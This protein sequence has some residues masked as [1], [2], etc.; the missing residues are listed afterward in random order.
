MLQYGEIIEKLS[1]DEKLSI[2]TDGRFLASLHAENEDIPALDIRKL[3]SFN[4]AGEYSYPAFGALANTWDCT[5]IEL[6]AKGLSER[7]GE[8]GVNATLLPKANVRSNVYGNGASED[9]YLLGTLMGQY[10]K[11]V[12]ENG[13]T[14][15][16]T[17]CALSDLDVAYADLTPNPKAIMEYYLNAFRI[18]TRENKNVALAT[19]YIPLKGNYEKTNLETVRALVEKHVVGK[20]AFMLCA[21]TSAEHTVAS[22]NAGYVLSVKGH[23]EVL[24]E[25]VGYYTAL[26]D[27]V[28]AGV[29]TAEELEEALAEGLA[30][31]EDTLNE[32][33]DSV[34]EFAWTCQENAKR[35][36]LNSY[37]ITEPELIRLSEQTSVLLKNEKNVLPLYGHK[38]VA[39]I[40]QLGKAGEGKCALDC[41]EAQA[42]KDYVGYADGYDL[43]RNRSDEL[44]A[45]AK[46]VAQKADVVLVFVG[47]GEAREKKLFETKCLT[48]PGAQTALLEELASVGKKLVVIVTG[49][50]RVDMRFD[51]CADAV[52]YAPDTST[53]A[54]KALSR[55]LFGQACPSGK[56]PFTMYDA[57]DERATRERFYKN[58][59]YNK[60]GS[61]LGYRR[62]ASDDESVKYPFGHGLS[63]TKFSYSNLHVDTQGLW[64]TIKNTGHCEGTEIVQLY[65]GNENEGSVSPRKQL[66]AYE[67]VTLKAGE[68]KTL[69]RQLKPAEF[70][71]YNVQA[72]KWEVEQGWY[73]I[74]ASSSVSD[75]RLH[76]KYYVLGT[77]PKASKENKSDYLQGS[78]NIVS[79]GF[80][81][82][83]NTQQVKYKSKA[84]LFGVIA[85]LLGILSDVLAV[86]IG[87]GKFYFPDATTALIAIILF[88]VFNF[89]MLLGIIALIVSGKRRRQFKREAEQGAL[90]RDTKQEEIEVKPVSYEQ[91]FLDEFS[92]IDED[93]DVEEEAD[94]KTEHEDKFVIKE[95][96]DSYHVPE[97]TLTQMQSD[98]LAF[99]A[100]RGIVMDAVQARTLL[101]AMSVSRLVVLKADNDA[102]ISALMRAIS[103]FF[104]VTPYVDDASAYA[105]SDD[106]L[107]RP[108]FAS[109]QQTDFA[110]ALENASAD[111][112]AIKI[113]HLTG[114]AL[115]AVSGY[116]TQFMRYV[117]KPDVSYNVALKN[118]SISD[119][120][121][122][123]SPNLWI[124]MS[125]GA[126]ETVENVPAYIAETATLVRV[127]FTIGADGAET[128]QT[129]V[130]RAVS[131]AQFL[132]FADK[133]KNTF[134]L[135][136]GKW[137]RVDKLEEYVRARTP[138]R[139]SNKL[140][141]KM[142][143]YASV[144]LSLGGEADEALDSVVA[145]KVLANVLALVKN[146]RK[147]GD[148]RFF[149]VLENIFGEEKANICRTVVDASG[150]DVEDA[151]QEQEL[152]NAPKKSTRKK[153]TEEAPASENEKTQS[154]VQ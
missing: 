8:A 33:V 131:K 120:V 47:F 15:I 9:P 113:A 101:S 14:P 28:E 94:E 81:M 109:Y 95:T 134:E 56:L 36:R 149:H 5:L 118:K 116:F 21:K 121:F 96:L 140:W 124:F 123:T 106:L 55:L 12:A 1:I 52:M 6:V 139:I 129:H 30:V 88:I 153:K 59:G 90:V 137:K 83:T 62:Y 151:W 152:Q 89:L 79:G 45:S 135:D 23:A 35:R 76:C 49:S 133:A 86:M 40:G 61:F 60:V 54:G 22:L 105:S 37:P 20:S 85:I 25:A 50:G 145:V 2:L 117:V 112:S 91:L 80:F 13:V 144:Y 66:F 110:R 102:D 108:L 26:R 115:S 104:A 98:M 92:A 136:E 17:S 64:L 122:T 97:L 132:S 82:D 16:L 127:K 87:S 70:A 34:L 147:E 27:S 29:A 126:E 39:V 114:V 19:S 93:D 43:S 130:G 100:E 11:S 71:S 48:L 107:Y 111:A 73:K 146:N 99:L 65:Y 7:A 78:S 53:Y 141:Q 142:E 63:Y 4:G 41:I 18:A 143:K 46:A 31:S 67:R 58:G 68:T 3:T 128:E 32:A 74:Y 119:K 51:A 69:H 154:E 42:G 75:E 77:P 72:D 148:E 103:A 10:A 125:L 138:Y 38:K 150:V 57:P 84:P 44:L 24:K